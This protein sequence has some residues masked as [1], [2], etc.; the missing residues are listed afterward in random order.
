MQFIGLQYLEIEIEV[1]FETCC[2]DI[3]L[4]DL[5][6]VGVFGK[7]EAV[8]ELAARINLNLINQKKKDINSWLRVAF[9]D[10]K[11]MT[12]AAPYLEEK[13]WLLPVEWVKRWC[14]FYGRAKKYNGNLMMD[15]VKK[16]KERMRLLKKYG[17]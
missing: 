16:S 1:C 8:D 15:G 9:P 3:L 4:D 17:L 12:N 5:I 13:P 11:F 6:E 14:R 10:K 7:N 2:P